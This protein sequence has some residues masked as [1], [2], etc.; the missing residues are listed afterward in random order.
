MIQLDCGNVL[1]KPSHRRHIL[2]HMRRSIKL[3]QKLGEFTLR[4]SLKRYGRGCEMKAV[5]HDLAGD[6]ACRCRRADWRD[7]T[8][9]IVRQVS[10]RLHRQRLAAA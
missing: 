1:L 4:L 5:V 3:G 8:R 2:T 6:F 9:E 10:S 7:A